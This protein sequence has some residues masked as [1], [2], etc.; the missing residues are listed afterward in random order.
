MA[1]GKNQEAQALWVDLFGGLL[2]FA[3]VEETR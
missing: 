3:Q 2:E 1:T